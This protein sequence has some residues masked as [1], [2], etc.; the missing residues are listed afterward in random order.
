MGRHAVTG[1]FGFTGKYV[2]ER[3]LQAGHEVITLTNSPNRENA[4]AGRVIP[5]RFQFHDVEAMAQDLEGVDVLYNT[6]WV[7]FNHASFTHAEAVHHTES[8]FKAA[9]LAGVKRVVHISITH[10]DE[11][12]PLEYF[13]GKGAL[14][15]VLKESGISYGIIR[16]AVLFGA[17]GILINNI[18][19]VLRYFPCFALFG[20]GRYHVQPIYVDDLAKLMIEVGAEEENMLINAL[21]EE[22]Y[23]YR[24]LV[25]L[26]RGELGVR[27]PMFSLPPALG[28]MA[29]YCIGKI[30]GDTFVT[31]EEIAGLMSDLLHVPGAPTLGKTRL[32]DWVRENKATLGKR[33]MGELIRRTDRTLRY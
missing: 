23:T 6:Y 2:A 30:V 20:D 1:A 18:A 10:A 29:S 12:S 33:Y 32:S 24:E 9:Q 4:F 21:G 22:D 15:R 28:Y 27:C 17:G 19:W 31:K 3:L 11:T 25:E 16:P 8:L 14:E 13:S 5:Y 7:R 26:I